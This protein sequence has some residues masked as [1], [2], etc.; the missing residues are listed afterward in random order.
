MTEEAPADVWC[1]APS[2]VNT[3]DSE[4][5]DFSGMTGMVGGATTDFSVVE[6]EEGVGGGVTEGNFCG[7]EVERC[8][9]VTPGS[10]VEE[11]E[12]ALMRGGLVVTTSSPPRCPLVSD[13]AAGVETTITST[14]DPPTERE[15]G[16]VEDSG[17]VGGS[18]TPPDGCGLS[19][20][21]RLSVDP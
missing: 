19:P 8:R 17:C 7:R 4:L 18:W 1:V 5:R 20:C 15:G 9:A 2:A 21:D 3:S 12:G 14:A 11:K 10:A 6:V 13:T 16:P